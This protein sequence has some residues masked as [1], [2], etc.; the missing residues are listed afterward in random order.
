MNSKWESINSYYTSSADGTM[1]RD[2]IM[3][4]K[5]EW[6]SIANSFQKDRDFHPGPS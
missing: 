2:E 1:R 5:V 6:D 3:S 4:S